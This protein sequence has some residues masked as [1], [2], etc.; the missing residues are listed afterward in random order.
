M[1]VLLGNPR[2]IVTTLLAQNRL[3]ALNPGTAAGNSS[4]LTD[5]E[6]T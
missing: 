6:K 4:A 2:L 1:I 3:H 5:I